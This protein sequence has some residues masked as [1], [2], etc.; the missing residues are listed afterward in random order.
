MKIRATVVSE[1]C[2]FTFPVPLHLIRVRFSFMATVYRTIVLLS[3]N[4]LMAAFRW[5]IRLWADISAGWL[6]LRGSE[7]K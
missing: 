4:F 7:R 3:R 2:V 6:Y 1:N 5:V